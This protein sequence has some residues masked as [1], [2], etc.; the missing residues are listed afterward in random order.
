MKPT[1]TAAGARGTTSMR[2]GTAYKGDLP[3]NLGT[4]SGLNLVNRPV[5][6]QGLGG[7]KTS[8]QGPK[9]T[10]YD[11]TYYL[12]Q[13]KQKSYEIAAEI[14][15]FR[16][17]VEEV[18]KEKGIYGQLETKYQEISK[19]VFTL[20]GTLADYNLAAD[21][22]RSRMKPEDIRQVYIH[23]RTMNDRYRHQLDEMFIERK[24]QEDEIREIEIELRDIEE[25]AQHKIAELS[26]EQRKEYEILAADKAAVVSDLNRSKMELD[27]LENKVEDQEKKLKMDQ[28]RIRVIDLK[29]QIQDLEQ[30]KQEL[31]ILCEE[32]NMSVSELVERIFQKIKSYNQVINEVEARTRDL[33][34]A[35]DN[36]NRKLK[37]MEGEISGGNQATDESKQKYEALFMK[38]QQVDKF[39]E[40]YPKLRQ[41]EFEEMAQKQQSVLQY[42]DNISQSVNLIRHAPDPE[43]V[44]RVKSDFQ[45]RQRNKQNSEDTLALVQDQYQTRL[46]DLEKIKNLQETAPQKIQAL[47]ERIGTMKSE[48]QKFKNAEEVKNEM[49]AKRKRLQDKAHKLKQLEDDYKRKLAEQEENFKKVKQNLSSHPKYA[50][51]MEL[52]KKI[53]QAEQAICNWKNLIATRSQE[54]DPEPQLKACTAVSTN[55]NNILCKT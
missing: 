36:N 50:G 17:R 15:M 41:K 33:K 35:I 13:L 20:E 31:E 27:E 28:N 18:D 26:T 49:F 38:E 46:Q 40:T 6:Q 43:M 22:Q 45:N 24:R 5:T 52:E 25:S 10:V 21:R 39:I 16:K 42:L 37:E 54:I 12:N 3:T 34:K 53:S 8:A 32:Q 30:K 47:K 55:I 4:A 44:E 11:R 23:L 7:V 29:Q 2:Q 51:F 9:R 48:M 1:G 14:Q 19:E